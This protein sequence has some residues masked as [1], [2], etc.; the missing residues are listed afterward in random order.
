[1]TARKHAEFLAA[2][3]LLSTDN[4]RLISSLRN[5]LLKAGFAV[6]VASDYNHLD[7]LWQELNPDIVLIEVSDSGS[8]E[9]AIK[10]ALRIK[11]RDAQQF[12]AYLADASLQ[13]GGLTGDAIFPRDASRLPQILRET[14]DSL[15]DP[16]H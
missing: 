16:S 10:A 8:V 12:V 11:Q 6:D 1:M 7:L 2:R 15:L 3:I 9:P 13:M 14:L 4:H 5:A